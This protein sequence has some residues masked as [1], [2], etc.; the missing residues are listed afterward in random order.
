[1]LR[2]VREVISVS[3]VLDNFTSRLGKWCSVPCKI[4]LALGYRGGILSLC[5]IMLALG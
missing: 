1:M 2:L 3:K 4:M 5:L